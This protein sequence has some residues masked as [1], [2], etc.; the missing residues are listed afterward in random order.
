M[1]FFKRLVGRLEFGLR[2]VAVA[3]GGRGLR[4]HLAFAPLEVPDLLLELLRLAGSLAQEAAVNGGAP[5]R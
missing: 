2:G 1:T 4:L 3:L 5:K